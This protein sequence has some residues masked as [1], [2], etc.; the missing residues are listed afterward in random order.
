MADILGAEWCSRREGTVRFERSV[1]PSRIQLGSAPSFRLGAL[2]VEPATRQVIRCDRSETIEPRVM[3]VLVALVQANG[4]VVTRDELSAACWGGAVVGDNAIQRTISRLRNLA[5]AFG[6]DSF[7]IDTIARV[8]YRL[9]QSDA[10]AVD[11]AIAGSGATNPLLSPPR[12]EL[13][14]G[15]VIGANWPEVLAQKPFIGVLPFQ[16]LSGDPKQGYFAEGVSEDIITALSRFRELLTAPRSS[17]FAFKGTGIDV[18]EVARDLGLQ[19]VLSGSMRKANKRVRV[20]AELT[21]CESGT[22]VWRERYDRKLTDIFDV[23][24]ELSRSVAAVILPALQIAEVERVR[25]K[26]PD[27]LTAYDLYLRALPHLWAGT[28]EEIS[29][30]ISLLRQSL[31]HESADVA[32]L[33]ALSLSLV[34]AVP[35][36]AE[37]PKEALSEALEHARKAIGLDDAHAFAQ[38]VYSIALACVSSEYDQAILHAEYA[39]RLNPSSTFAQGALG[40]ASHFA[41]RF[42]RALENLDIAVRLSP[43]DSYV[44]LWLTFMAAADFGLER[45]DHGVDAARKAIQRNPN[46]GTAHRLLAANLALTGRIDMAL[47]VTRSRDVIQQTSVRELR[48]MGLF[49]QEAVVERYV[50]AQRLCGV[51]E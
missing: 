14:K 50:A 31:Q 24:D 19:Y 6:T 40:M 48:V 46:Y 4:A 34:L 42:D 10:R 18:A 5:S 43:S 39:V 27:D 3:Q 16:N 20:T 28:R 12:S 36:G 7:H 41:G 8:G 35:L 26:A 15:G 47:H 25:R 13:L 29:T 32:A 22:E 38:A 1:K 2:E 33:C 45:Y 51:A 30:A 9:L 49:R 17:T 23:Q 37:P 44:Y 21:H 11:A